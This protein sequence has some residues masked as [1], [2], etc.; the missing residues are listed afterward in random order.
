MASTADEAELDVDVVVLGAGPAGENVAQYAT[1][2]TELTCA[3]VEGELV[4]G[5]CSYYACMPS[6]ALLRPLEIAATAGQLGGLRRP[7]VDVAGVLARRDYWV[8]RY[9]DAGQIAW[10]ESTG[11]Q[12][13]RGHGRLAG[14]RLVVVGDQ[15][16]RARHAVVIGTGSVPVIPPV[17]AQVSPWTSRDATGVVEIP[18]RLVVVG[19]GVVACE[20]ATWLAGLGSAVTMLV[21][22]DRLLP[23]Q[24]PFAGEA[25]LAALTAAGVTVHRQTDV[26][27]C[28]RESP[29]ETGLGRIHGGP[30]TMQTSAGP[31]VADE[32]LV[33]VGRRPR[34]R[35]LGLES[36][37]LTPDDVLAGRLPDWLSAVG[38][39]S[40]EPALTH[41]G[42]YRARVLGEQI[43]AAALG[44]AASPEVEAPVPQVIFTDPQVAAVGLTQESARSSGLDIA[45]ARVPYASA[46]GAAL[47]RDE[48]PGTAQLVVDRASGAVVGATF[49]G[50]DAGELVH[51]ATVAIVTGAPVR[52]LRH[53]V[54]S[55]PTA[56]E[57]W[58]RL[59]EDLPRDLR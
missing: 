36:V 22:G 16:L 50:P 55:Y 5:E 39:A 54:P 3:L 44:R 14:E 51:A 29:R 48:V 25:V 19:G 30:L 21:R 47:L 1:E 8:S 33:A 24:E 2:D 35:D 13:V 31:I 12:V 58:L 4:G 52:L 18:Q 15:R 59:L 49:V 7:E 34:L 26:Q 20:A 23:G 45:I 56:S 6:K 46:A 43:A 28:R 42:K 41:W 40:G 37:G 57:L 53:A 9:D 10:A 32:I 27:A 11:L 38:D 17:Y